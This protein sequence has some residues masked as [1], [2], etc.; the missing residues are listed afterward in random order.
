MEGGRLEGPGGGW[1]G[2]SSPQQSSPEELKGERERRARSPGWRRG[3]NERGCRPLPG[4]LFKGLPWPRRQRI[5][6]GE[7]GAGAP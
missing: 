4:D 2:D 6:D 5:A 7:A 3:A 1:K